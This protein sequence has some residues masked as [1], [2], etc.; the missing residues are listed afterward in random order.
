MSFTLMELA[1]HPK[2][3]EKAR[4]DIEKA[5]EKH[6]LTYEAFND[7]KY[8]DQCIA[9]GVRLH[10]PVSTIDRYTRQDYKVHLISKKIIKLILFLILF[11]R[12]A[13]YFVLK[14]S[15]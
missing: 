6:G 14:F 4:K 10:P 13:K 9:E 15:F 3:Q 12:R 2:Y 11:K 7:M 8:L 5:I 1:I